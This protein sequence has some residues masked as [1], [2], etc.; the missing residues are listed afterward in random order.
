M[1]D[2]IPL[3][4][5][6][7]HNNQSHNQLHRTLHSNNQQLM[8]RQPLPMDNLSTL[9]KLTDNLLLMVNP[10]HLTLKINPLIPKDNRLTVRLHLDTHRDSKPTLNSKCMVNQANLTVNQDKQIPL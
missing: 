5:S 9:S 2:T 10:N 7:I 8:A 1:E 6:K 3:E 4:T